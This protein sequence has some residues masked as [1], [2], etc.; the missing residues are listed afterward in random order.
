MP[1]CSAQAFNAY[2]ESHVIPTTWVVP[3]S[4]RF[5]SDA[6][7]GASWFQVPLNAK[8]MNATTTRWPR[9]AESVIARPS[10]ARSV[11]T[12]M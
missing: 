10:C 8:A 9:R 3:A 1:S 12:S 11:C 4:Y 7:A 6:S 5:W 2:T